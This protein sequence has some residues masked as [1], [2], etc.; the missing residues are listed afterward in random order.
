[1]RENLYGGPLIEGHEP[2]RR[3]GMKCRR[4][5]SFSGLLGGYPGTYKGP[6]SRL[7]E[8]EYEEGYE[9]VEE[10]ESDEIEVDSALVNSPEAPE[11]PNLD[12]SNQPIVSKAEPNLLKMM[13]K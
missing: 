2:S 10:G 9:S 11:A 1:M 12:L 13:R 6:K 7:G 3:G 4:S 8:A 5:R